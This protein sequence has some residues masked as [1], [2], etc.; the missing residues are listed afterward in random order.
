LN[1]IKSCE[2]GEVASVNG[3][4]IGMD[5][6]TAV[7]RIDARFCKVAGCDEYTNGR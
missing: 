6:L 1:N 5:S 7:K 3:I 2:K 4:H